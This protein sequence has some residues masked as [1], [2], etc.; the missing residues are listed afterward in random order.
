[1]PVSVLSRF[2]LFGAYTVTS[3]S[4]VPVVLATYRLPEPSSASVA[5]SST[6][7]VIA[8]PP[9]ICT[10][11]FG[12]V[13]ADVDRHVSA[14]YANGGLLPDCARSFLVPRRGSAC[15]DENGAATPTPQTD[16]TERAVRAARTRFNLMVAAVRR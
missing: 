11:P 12:A 15:A 8:G 10:S 5:G 2:T 9:S 16:S 4:F 14:T 3:P 13:Q 7:A 1:M 6:P